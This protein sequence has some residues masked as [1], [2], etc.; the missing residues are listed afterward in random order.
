MTTAQTLLWIEP[1]MTEEI[2]NKAR[3][4]TVVSEHFIRAAMA[5]PRIARLLRANADFQTALQALDPA[6][7]VFVDDDH[8]RN[9]IQSGCLHMI[10]LTT[11]VVKFAREIQ[12]QVGD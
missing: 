10:D 5:E 11:A 6:Q 9:V 7:P 1:G 3:Q 8:L 12:V 4:H 2:R